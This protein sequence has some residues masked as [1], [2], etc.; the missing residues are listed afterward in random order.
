MIT[1]LLTGTA[2]IGGLTTITDGVTVKA[3]NK[4]VSIQNAAGLTKV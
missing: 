3:D 1:S 2:D 4:L